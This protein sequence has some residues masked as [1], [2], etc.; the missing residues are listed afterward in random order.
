MPEN[1]AILLKDFCEKE[2]LR[3][4]KM[5]IL[6]NDQEWKDSNIDFIHKAFS[7]YYK[8]PVLNIKNIIQSA[9]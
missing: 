5:V 2:K 3:P 8:V 4:M 1:M 9:K 7:E 6:Q